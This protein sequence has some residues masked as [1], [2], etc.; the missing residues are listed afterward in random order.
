[1]KEYVL[2]VRVHDRYNELDIRNPQDLD[3]L[4]KTLQELID[5][6]WGTDDDIPN[7]TIKVTA[8]IVE[9]VP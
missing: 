4:T 2:T 3:Y 8:C 6:G 5:D 7:L 9:E 1:M